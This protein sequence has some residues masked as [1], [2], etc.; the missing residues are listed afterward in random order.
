MTGSL[1]EI[2]RSDFFRDHPAE[3][4]QGYAGCF[5]NIT[6]DGRVGQDVS[7]TFRKPIQKFP[8]RDQIGGRHS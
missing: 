4:R 6:I 8:Q 2:E 3:L 5:R 1:T 7:V